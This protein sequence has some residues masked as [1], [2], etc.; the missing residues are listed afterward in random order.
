MPSHDWTYVE[1][2]AAGWSLKPMPLF[3]SADR[4]VNVPLETTYMSALP[5]LTGISSKCP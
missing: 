1:Q 4:Y 2:L 3:L 5:G